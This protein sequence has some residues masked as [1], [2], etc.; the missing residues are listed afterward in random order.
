MTI[1]MTIGAKVFLCFGALLAV[2]GCYD[3][4]AMYN[5]Q[6]KYESGS[7]YG[8]KAADES[9]CRPYLGQ[10]VAPV[11][12]KDAVAPFRKSAPKSEFEAAWQYEKRLSAALKKPN[13]EF[14]IEKAPED[15]KFLDY[16]AGISK[17]TISSYAFSNTLMDYYSAI[18]SAGLDQKV[19]PD[20][21]KNI[22]VVMSD[23]TKVLGVHR[24][25]RRDGSS[26]L[27][28]DVHRTVQAIF[29][30][31]SQGIRHNLFP[32]ADEAP[33]DVGWLY[34]SPEEAKRLKPRLKL[35]FVVVPKDPYFVMGSHRPTRLTLS[36]PGNVREDFS[37]LFAD[38]QC[39]LVLD[40]RN[41]VL[42]SYPTR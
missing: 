40:D 28:Y 17:L 38:I 30:G 19:Q 21:D 7:L 2:S 27:S 18:S 5:Y 14:I 11:T 23:K 36:Q 29:D 26:V 6:Y 13:G 37:I 10:I 32:A 3:R 1:G 41:K 12:F 39:G 16:N 25:T 24:T 4:N 42:G 35:A 8:D 31:A 15:P 22:E 34:L 20:C 33:H 9:R